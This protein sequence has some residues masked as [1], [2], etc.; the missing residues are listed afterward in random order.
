MSKPNIFPA[1]APV[2]K[3]EMFRASL[4]AFL[5]LLV[6]G[7]TTG[8][9][10]TDQAAI[11]ILVAPMG[12]SAVLLFGAPTSPFAQPWSILAGNTVA[13]LSGLIILLAVD[14][15]V[16]A[17]SLA[18]S[19]TIGLMF[20]SNCIHPPSG[21][22]ALT[23]IL[24]QPTISEFGYHAVVAPISLNSLILLSM[25]VLFNNLSGKKYPHIPV[26]DTGERSTQLDSLHLSTLPDD[27]NQ[28]LKRYDEVLNV[29]PDQLDWIMDQVQ[30]QSYQRKL[31]GFS[32]GD[33]MEPC[34]I[35]LSPR[36]R[37][38]KA[39]STLR[40][41]GL[42][43][44]PVVDE[45]SRLVGIVS[46]HDFVRSR[47][48]SVEGQVGGTLTSNV[49]SLLSGTRFLRV[50]DIMTRTV[51]SADSDTPIAKL[52]PALAEKGLHQI[53]II[54][55]NSKVIGMVTQANLIGALLTSQ[56]MVTSSKCA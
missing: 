43:A 35:T 54:D 46:Q 37:L 25:A 36:L 51:V 23:V 47:A 39:W 4:G 1:L 49:E 7:F 26:T 45:N 33:I 41:S 12:A 42:N 56:E 28:A 44:L 17:A 3:R 27:L 18:V 10:M 52:V 16:L 31:K 9:F 22:V 50:E 55:I 24:S 30:L 38:N 13:L 14:D 15:V 34:G 20:F 8:M 21:A 32:C 40:K 19:L 11:G 2:S 53:P 5:G 29:S 6:S 48:L